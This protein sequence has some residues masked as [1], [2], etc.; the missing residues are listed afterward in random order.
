MVKPN[1]L[2]VGFAK[3]GTTTFYNIMEQHKDIFLSGIKEPI[4]YN[5]EQFYR[6][7]FIWYQK[8]YYP[9]KVKQK[10]IMEVNP[11]LGKRISAKN[12]QQ[13]FGK[14]IKIIF[15]IRNPMERLYSNFKMNLTLGGGF[16]K[17]EDNIDSST[18]KLFHKWLKQYYNKKEKKFDNCI[19]TN[20]VASGEYYKVIKDYI[21]TFGRNNI[22]VIIFEEFIKNTEIICKDVYKFLGIENDEK[23][24][25]NIHSNEGNRLPINKLSIKLNRFYCYKICYGLLLSKLPYVSRKFCK[26][27]DYLSW[28]GHLKFFSKK[29]RHPE[30]M[31]SED[32]LLLRDY[33]YNDIKKLGELIDVN[34]IE[35]WKM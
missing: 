21:N 9:K 19:K 25:Y 24:N 6:K 12:I 15:L 10:V 16:E 2:C 5:R 7:G 11:I 35:K 27:I 31:L 17:C 28:A 34:L 32:K 30:K 4:Y 29:D 22:K 3:C 13:D 33:Y 18:S 26:F 20:N 14:D 1:V 23:V 8:R